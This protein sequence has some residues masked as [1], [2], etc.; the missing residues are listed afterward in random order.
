MSLS[1]KTPIGTA[2][3][4]EN[5][6]LRHR[7]DAGVHVSSAAATDTVK[8]LAELLGGRRAPVI[9]DIGGVSHADREARDIF[10]KLGASAPAI[11]TA[12]LVRPDENPE[13]AVQSFLFSTHDMLDRPVAIFEDEKKAVAWARTFL[14]AT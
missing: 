6:I 12:I 5:G 1:T 14:S 8:V 9:V 7:L 13:S 2:W 11:A 3:F 10:A 4:D